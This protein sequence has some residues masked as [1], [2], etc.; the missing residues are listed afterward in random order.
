MAIFLNII[1]EL[2]KFLGRDMVVNLDI[3]KKSLDR[4]EQF[5]HGLCP[6]AKLGLGVVVPAK[7]FALPQHPGN[8]GGLN[9]SA[10]DAWAPMT[11]RNVGL[12]YGQRR[13]PQI[14]Q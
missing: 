3:S 4:R 12:Q 10:E 2:A 7:Q 14:L 5:H 11:T 8:R 9:W 1:N 13:N 6:M